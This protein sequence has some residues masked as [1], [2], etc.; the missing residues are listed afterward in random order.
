MAHTFHQLYYHFIWAT[1]A[2]A[3][4]IDRSWRPQM[5][6]I[7]SAEVRDKGGIPIRHNAMPDHVHLLV[8]LPP[9]IAPSEFVGKVKGATSYRVNRELNPKFKLQWQEGYGVL[10]L[11]RDELATVARYID[12][13]E[14]HHNVNKLSEALET[15]DI[16]QDDWG[17]EWNG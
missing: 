14:A 5:L 3:T 7:I 15:I 8:R 4:L 10:S 11:R 17:M 6:N 16:E 12:R 9:K 1:H 2:R 13:Q